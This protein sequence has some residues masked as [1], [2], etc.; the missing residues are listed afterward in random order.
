MANAFSVTVP[1]LQLNGQTV[2]S[3]VN[4][5]LEMPNLSALINQSF[6]FVQSVSAG[7]QA[8]VQNSIKQSQAFIPQ[9][10]AQAAPL[11]QYE[12]QAAEANAQAA[13]A[14]QQSASQS[15]GGGCFITTAL[16][17]YEGKA[18]DCSELQTLRE[19][20]DSYMLADDNRRGMVAIYY[21]V[22][23]MIVERLSRLNPDHRESIYRTIGGFVQHACQHIRCGHF[24]D[25]R[26]C[27]QAMIEFAA[28]EVRYE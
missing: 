3:G 20:R 21:A 11:Y 1:P 22:A 2:P 23:P 7:N 4:F 24:N 18:D 15:A 8:F 6:G 9:I 13:I 10:F 12:A 16:C 19:F 17:E 25:A 27:Y 14:A 26:V 28:S 5:D